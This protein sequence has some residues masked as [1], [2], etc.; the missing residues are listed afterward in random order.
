M[1]VLILCDGTGSY[2]VLGEGSKCSVKN[3]YEETGVNNGG[4]GFYNIKYGQQ[5]RATSE[6]LIMNTEFLQH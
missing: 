4:K 3:V 6:G 2:D 1:I 5:L